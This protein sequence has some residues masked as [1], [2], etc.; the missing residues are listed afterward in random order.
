MKETHK[1]YKGDNF[2]LILKEFIQ[3]WQI[4]LLVLSNFEG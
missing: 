2:I 1:L 3:K 4:L